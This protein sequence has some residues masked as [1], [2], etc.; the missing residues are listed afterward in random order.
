MESVDFRSVVPSLV[1]FANS[2]GLQSLLAR[3]LGIDE[4]EAMYG[5]LRST[6]GNHALVNRLLQVLDVTY[7]IS[8][9]DL[10]R[11]PQ[12]GPAL[13][14]VNHPYGI[15]DGAVIATLLGRIRSDLRLLANE[16]ISFIP[17]LQDLLIPVDPISGRAAVRS[18]SHGARQSIKHLVGKGMLVVFPAGEVSH[19]QWKGKSITDAEWNP[20]VARIVAI[21]W[22]L[23][24]PLPVIPVY[25]KGANS[26]LFH[27]TGLLHSGFRTALL[28]RELLNK[29]G[30]RIEVR[31]G[32][33]VPA[34]KLLALPTPQEQTRYLRWRTYLLANRKHETRN[35]APFRGRPNANRVAKPIVAARPRQLIAMEAASLPILARSGNLAVYMASAS[36]IPNTLH[37]IGRLREITFRAAG[38]GTGK[39]VDIDRFDA[40]YLHL[41]CWDTCK[42]QIVGAYRL[43]RADAVGARGLYTATVFDYGD[44]LLQ[45]LGPALELGRFFISPEYQRRIAPLLL[46]WKG[47]GEYVAQNPQCKLLFGSV[48]ISN[49]YH[50]V[51]RDLM[52][53]F[54]QRHA[55]LQQWANLLG[56]RSEFRYDG[57]GTHWPVFDQSG[58]DVE[59]LSSVVAD[60]D[61]NYTG[62]PVLLR[63]YLKLG[64]KL[65]GFR[66]DPMF[67]YSLDGLILVD[68]TK[69]DP[70]LLARYIGK[71]NA[72]SFLKNYDHRVQSNRECCLNFI[73]SD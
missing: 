14:A 43:A 24:T 57:P 49:R 59:D 44:E 58:F 39:E 3:A 64:G 52:V 21:L 28:G 56:R 4:L 51:S 26:L 53:S 46:L 1:P 61:P 2:A 35:I 29:R 5:L 31:V 70:K 19:F 27:I 11:I 65:L 17:E 12:S 71:E 62:V 34:E 67:S 30:R 45:R 23:G 50:A 38:E 72:A 20:A 69:A 15:L 42:I 73:D 55:S 68:L 22:R 16:I 47:I 54:L 33:A 60:V 10:D 66:V 6:S 40:H 63:Q 8:D 13:V 9:A 36:Q 18:N 37:E 7:H 25:V 41:F 48:S 32:T